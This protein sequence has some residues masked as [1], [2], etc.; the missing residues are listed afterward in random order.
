MSDKQV[1]VIE[2]LDEGVDHA[3]G[4]TGAALIVEY[5][6]YECP[7]SRQAYRAITRVQAQL[8]EGI[9]FAFRHFPLTEIHPHALAASRAA[10]AAAM[11]NR[12]W[13]M[14]E[15]LF[16]RQQAL[17]DDDLRAY[18]SELRLDVA[19]FDRDRGGEAVL[20]RIRRDVDSG[21]AS[22]EVRGTPTL[23]I[24]GVVH[25]GDYATATLLGVLGG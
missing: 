5:G 19:R 16:R 21:I 2:P 15:M 6:D 25:R 24:D 10:E 3:R 11:Q 8:G 14:H 13:E 23:F 1:S 17:E 9:R 20:E 4:P 18:A 22:G 7:Y 12:F